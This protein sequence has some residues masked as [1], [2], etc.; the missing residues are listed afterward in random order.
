M[1]LIK[2]KKK[3]K[4]IYLIVYCVC[5]SSINYYLMENKIHLKKYIYKGK[6]TKKQI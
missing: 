1:K 2:K 5:S 4:K 6:G 3:K